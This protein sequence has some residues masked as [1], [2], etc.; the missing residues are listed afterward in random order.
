MR[1]QVAER[2]RRHTTS[3]MHP[4]N[5]PST[6]R[7]DQVASA[8]SRGWNCE[9]FGYTSKTSEASASQIFISMGLR[10]SWASNNT[11]RSPG[12]RG[13]HALCCAARGDAPEGDFGAE[14]IKI[15]HPARADAARGHGPSKDGAGLWVQDAR[16]QQADWSRSTS[17]RLRAPSL[18]AGWPSGRTWCWRTS[19]PGHW[20]D[21]GSAGRSAANP[22]LVLARVSGF[23][24][25][26]PDAPRP[27]FGTLAEAMSGF[28]SRN[29][30]PDGPPLLPPL[31]LA[32]GVAGLATAFATP[33]R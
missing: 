9:S 2:S 15:E 18:P 24:Q 32:D 11:G 28:A 19:V 17:P 6:R 25:T 20:S 31:A 21:G 23:G 26:G 22:Q 14:V 5:P 29:G 7:A 10:A 8:Q 12:R 3:P 4:T 27:G 16:P 13:G 33:P 1:V 30:E